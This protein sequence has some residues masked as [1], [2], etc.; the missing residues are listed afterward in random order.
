MTETF[1]GS[2]VVTHFALHHKDVTVPG[3]IS[4]VTSSTVREMMVPVQG[5]NCNGDWPESHK[6]AQKLTSWIAVIISVPYQAGLPAKLTAWPAP[7]VPHGC[8]Q[9]CRCT[10]LHP[11]VWCWTD[12]VC[13]VL[14]HCS[15]GP[16]W[17]KDTCFNMMRT[18]TKHSLS[19]FLCLIVSVLTVR[20][21]RRG[22]PSWLQPDG[23]ASVFSHCTFVDAGRWTLHTSFTRPPTN[24]VV[25]SG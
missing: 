3:G 17:R 25:F 24:A 21:L 16:S 8:F 6:E 14:M 12:A 7:S 20:A 2:T 13:L 1:C 19:R 18:E 9:P 10:L 11:P 4:A 15:A 23:L 5:K 22:C